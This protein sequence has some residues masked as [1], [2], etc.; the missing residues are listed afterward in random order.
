MR[1]LLIDEGAYPQHTLRGLPNNL[2]AAIFQLEQPQ[3][4]DAVRRIIKE[5]EAATHGDDYLDLF[6]WSQDN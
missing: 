5:L 2:A 3:T 4:L 6:R 1:Y